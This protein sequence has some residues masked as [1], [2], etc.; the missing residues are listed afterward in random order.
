MTP[1]P[2]NAATFHSYSIGVENNHG[3]TYTGVSSYRIDQRLPSHTYVVYQSMW[4]NL[5]N[6]AWVELG[7]WHAPASDAWYWGYATAGG[8]WHPVGSRYITPGSWHTFTTYRSGT[9]TWIFNIDG[10]G[11]GQFGTSSTW[12]GIGEQAGLESWDPNVTVT[13]YSS[14][15]LQYQLGG[16]WT[17]WE[18]YDNYAIG[19]SM[20]GKWAS[21]T[22]WNSGEHTTCG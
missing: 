9:T 18:G 17:P 14:S 11:W 22:Q 15:S 4:L 7:T 12:T 6:Y 20:C 13:E 2:R 16:F 10:V 1:A 3:Q 19:L 8:S 21:P 5:P